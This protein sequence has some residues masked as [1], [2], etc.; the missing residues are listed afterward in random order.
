MRRMAVDAAAFLYRS[1][2]HLEGEL[3]R[4]ILMTPHTKRPRTVTQQPGEPRAN[5]RSNKESRIVGG[6]KEIR[7]GR[8]RCVIG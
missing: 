7:E 5:R 1:V 6:R 8:R 3:F 2:N 4:Q